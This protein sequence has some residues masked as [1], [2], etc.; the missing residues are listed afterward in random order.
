MKYLKRLSQYHKCNKIPHDFALATIETVRIIPDH[1]S[2]PAVA[3]RAGRFPLT[4][5]GLPSE[6]E[7]L[8]FHVFP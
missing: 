3:V 8:L 2:V 7:S 4:T 1:E 5:I 6:T